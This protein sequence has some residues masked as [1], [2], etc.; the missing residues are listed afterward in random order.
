ML[1][2]CN[3]SAGIIS[4]KDKHAERNNGAGDDS[5]ERYAVANQDKRCNKAP[6]P[7]R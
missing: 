5:F 1:H 2:M 7:R 4:R 6:Q 3:Y